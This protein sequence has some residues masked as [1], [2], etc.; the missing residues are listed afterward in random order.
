VGAPQDG[1][2][3]EGLLSWNDPVPG[4][5]ALG[6]APRLAAGK[7]RPAANSSEM[8]KAILLRFLIKPALRR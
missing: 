1:S 8:P 5:A 6:V 2:S 4:Q 3:S 7:T